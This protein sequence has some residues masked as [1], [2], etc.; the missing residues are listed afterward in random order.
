MLTE[1]ALTPHVF[2]Q[3]SNPDTDRWLDWLYELG[4]NIA[5]RTAA[6]PVMTSDLFDG[7]WQHETLGIVQTI[8]D[9]RAK[10]RVQRILQ[11][12]RKLCVPRPAESSWPQDESDWANE[13]AA[14]HRR[15]PLGRIVL[16]NDMFRN[17]QAGGCPCHP[18]RSVETDAFWDGIQSHGPV[19]MDIPSQIALL[20]PL[21]VHSDYLALR[22][23]HIRG[24]SDDETPFAARLIASACNR[25]PGY[26]QPHIDLHLDGT[27]VVNHQ[28]CTANF[29][30]LVGNISH[31]LQR[32]VP[33]GTNVHCYFWPNFIKRVLIAGLLQQ[34]GG[35]NVRYPRWGVELA[36]I[37]RPK[38]TRPSEPWGLVQ[39]K[40]LA[41]LAKQVNP[42]SPD[43]LH[44][45]VLSF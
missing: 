38:D 4:R 11:Q 13:A 5:P 22:S 27:T 7:N 31:I 19:P 24:T 37:A 26:G 33:A 42:H 34:S 36:H 45:E 2:D 3:E 23:P 30:N 18:L 39:Q 35:A 17:F 20:R 29:S 1:I 14:S 16:T 15:E 9:H 43:I 10:D 25:P 21:C 44:A 12:I 41:D 8:S 28:R 40:N 32:H 6:A